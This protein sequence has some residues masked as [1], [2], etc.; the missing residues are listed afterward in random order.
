MTLNSA[1]INSG[2]TNLIPDSTIC[3]GLT[4]QDCSDVHVV[5]SGDICD[6]IMQKAGINSTMLWGNNPQ[7]NQECT[8]IYT[9][10]VSLVLIA[11]VF[12]C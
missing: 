3:L 10:E 9:G 1:F 4:G 6:D 8:N 2:C 7:I 11:I 5:Q 12:Y